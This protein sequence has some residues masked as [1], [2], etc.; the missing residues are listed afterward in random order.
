[1]EIDPMVVGGVQID[2]AARNILRIGDIENTL[3][4]RHRRVIGIRRDEQ[5]QR[6]LAVDIQ[7]AHHE[8]KHIVVIMLDFLGIGL[9]DP[10]FERRTLIVDV[11]NERIALLGVAETGADTLGQIIALVGIGQRRLVGE[12]CDRKIG[13]RDVA[14][15]VALLVVVLGT[16]LHR[17]LRMFG[18]RLGIGKLSAQRM[19]ARRSQ[20]AQ[21]PQLG[22]AFYLL[23]NRIDIT[24]RRIPTPRHIA[25]VGTY[26]RSGHNV[27]IG[28]GG[29]SEIRITEHPVQSDRTP[30][31]AQL[32]TVD[33]VG[34]DIVAVAGSLF[35]IVGGGVAA[36][37]VL[38]PLRPA[39]RVVGLVAEP[40]TDHQILILRNFPLQTGVETMV[41]GLRIGITVGR[42]R[43]GH[44]R[45]I[46]FFDRRTVFRIGVIEK[47]T[48]LE[49]HLIALAPRIGIV[50][51]QRIDAGHAILRPHHILTHAATT[52]AARAARHAENVFE[53]EILLVHIVEK[54]DDRYAAIA[55]ENIHV[56]TS[57]V[58]ELIL[59]FG[60]GIVTQPGIDLA[61]LP[62]T[63][64]F[65]GHDIDRLI[66][67]AIVHAREFGGIA[68]LVVHL[69]A[70][71]RL[72]R[73]RLDGR[74]DIL[75]EEL[76]AVDKNLLDLL[77]LGL[78]RAVGDRDAGHLL[79]KALHIGIGH[80]LEC[81]GIVTYRIALLRGTQRLDLL[82]HGLYLHAG[83]QP[84][85]ADI[86]PRSRDRKRRI[87]IIIPQERNGQG[88]LAIRKRRNRDRT[89]ISRSEILFLLRSFH[90]RDRQDGTGNRLSSLFVENR[91][92][93]AA[94]LGKRNGCNQ[95]KQGG[96]QYFFHF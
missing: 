57:D 28:I 85:V 71:D 4:L 14:F 45:G 61:E 32:G 89:P 19:A 60:V 87:I 92:R 88:I 65:M 25:T 79:Q 18:H 27:G 62:L 46:P 33:G 48:T 26:R 91:R 56:A 44:R 64:V 3:Q 96:K 84:D 13:A 22:I 55:V 75:A 5:P 74:S 38:P 83:L 67:F 40:G 41:V 12:T 80:D 53:R 76:L 21:I 95:S 72:R 49:R 51:T 34:A 11:G 23:G 10:T 39:P 24:P 77:A 86:L 69:D 50:D 47:I 43:I 66:A 78:D 15:V 8:V 2:I 17:D 58:F 30:N 7:L 93:D 70:V 37:A 16:I 6:I 73:Q 81:P 36:L 20:G 90:G 54:P 82:D 59:G 52:T 35:E 42:K 68:Q 1:M 31:L 9:H 94:F 29:I 63:H